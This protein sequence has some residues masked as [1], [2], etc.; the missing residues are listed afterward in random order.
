M[1]RSAS[2]AWWANKHVDVASSATYT[3]DHVIARSLLLRSVL[4]HFLYGVLCISTCLVR[5]NDRL[6]LASGPS[7]TPGQISDIVLM[8]ANQL[9]VTFASSARCSH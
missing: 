4:H 6:G 7:A 9:R 5:V 1:T 8:I 2:D 3:R